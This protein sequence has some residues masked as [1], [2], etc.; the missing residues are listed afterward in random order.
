MKS[1]NLNKAC[2]TYDQFQKQLRLAHT[3]AIETGDRFAEI[4]IFNL[5]HDSTKIG[6]ELGRAKEAAQ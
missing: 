6:Y 2:D 1:E 5:L 4:F 3:D